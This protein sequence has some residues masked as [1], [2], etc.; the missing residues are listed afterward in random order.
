MNATRAL[1]ATAAA[2]EA[3]RGRPAAPFATSTSPVWRE[4]LKRVRPPA[5]APAGE[6]RLFWRLDAGSDPA[7]ASVRVVPDFGGVGRGATRDDGWQVVTAGDPVTLVRGG[8]ALQVATGVVSAGTFQHV[9]VAA[10]SAVASGT[11]GEE[12]LVTHVEP[13]AERVFVPANGGT[14]VEIVL[15]ALRRPS[16][17]TR[18]L[19][20]KDAVVS[21][22][23][24]K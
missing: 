19:F 8:P 20:V 16:S 15:I 18:Q 13:I 11:F 5:G 1:P 24:F 23:L 9:F 10:R 22:G 6:L 17:D 2:F 3:V 7:V 14:A 21:E 12:T 4:A